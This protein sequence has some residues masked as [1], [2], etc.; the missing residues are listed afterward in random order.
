VD[1]TDGKQ[2]RTNFKRYSKDSFE[3]GAIVIFES[4][5]HIK[6]AVLVP[7]IDILSNMKAAGH[8]SWL[9]MKAHPRATCITEQLRVISG[10]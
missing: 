5:Y 1:G 8:V 10:E 9:T 6:G 7:I 4:S 2:N 3:Y